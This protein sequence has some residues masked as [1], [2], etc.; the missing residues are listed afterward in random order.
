MIDA[1]NMDDVDR[2]GAATSYFEVSSR[3]D[4]HV[5]A[6]TYVHDEM[7]FEAE[8]YDDVFSNMRVGR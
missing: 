7:W 8:L 2:S 6:Y 5:Y 3:V 4:E 1:H